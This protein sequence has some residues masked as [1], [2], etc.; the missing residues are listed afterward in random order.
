MEVGDSRALSGPCGGALDD[1]AGLRY[2]TAQCYD[3]LKHY[4]E[5]ELRELQKN[6]YLEDS[7][8]G[9]DWNSPE[10]EFAPENGLISGSACD[11][12]SYDF[13]CQMALWLDQPQDITGFRT[14]M[15]R[16]AESINRHFLKDGYYETSTTEYIPLYGGPMGWRNAPQEKIPVGYRQASNLMPLV[17]GIVPDVE[18][19]KVMNGL[20]ADIH[21]RDNHLDTGC[22]ASKSLLT[23]LSNHGQLELAYA[24]A[25]QRTFPSWGFWVEHGATTMWEH[26]RYDSRSRNHFFLGAGI[27]EWLF[28]TL[29]GFRDMQEGFR[30]VTIRPAFP[31]ELTSLHVSMETVRGCFRIDWVREETCITLELLVPPNISAC[32]ELPNHKPCCLGGGSYTFYIKIR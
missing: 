16:I 21:A 6:N 17:Y 9:G 5:S 31:K 26:W 1:Y 29:A 18:R 11:Y 22:I 24:I 4:M 3:A 14:E 25:N 15:E 7:N 23:Y 10:G 13:L 27:Q 32:V 2:H 28:K 30:R 12:H 19:D 8:T 20:I